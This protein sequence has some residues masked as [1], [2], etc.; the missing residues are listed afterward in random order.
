MQ[1]IEVLKPQVQAAS[2]TRMRDTVGAYVDLTKPGIV[3]FLL[4]TGLAGMVVAQGGFPSPGRALLTLIGLALSSGGANAINMWYDR[5]IDAVMQRTLGRPI[6]SGRLQPAQALAFGIVSGILSFVLLTLTVN[7]V[8]ALLA[9]AGYLFYVLVYTFWLKRRTPQNIVIGGAAG[10]FPPV[11]GWAAVTG[12]VSVAALLMFMIIF[13]WTPPHFWA[14]AL[15][16]QDD[17]RTAGIPMMPVV[18]GERVT[19]LQSVVYSMVLVATSAMLWWTHVVGVFYLVA[20]LVL[21]VGF[22]AVNVLLLIEP[23]AQKA[24]AKTVFRYSLVYMC[25]I[26]AS[27]MVGLPPR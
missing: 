7:L 2:A 8:T 23:P 26:F 17:Y 25:G 21:G 6:P 16:K 3:L 18:H 24:R 9:A 19:K 10:A 4:I 13:L 20:A 15:R 1:T 12:H 14:L 11:V 27:M 22:V 5:D